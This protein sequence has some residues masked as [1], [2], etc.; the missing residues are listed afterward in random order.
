MKEEHYRKVIE[1]IDA[2][3]KFDDQQQPIASWHDKQDLIKAIESL[4]SDNRDAVIEKQGELKFI[5]QLIKL[6]SK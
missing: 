3:W 2:Y 4:P 6:S 1:L 5:S